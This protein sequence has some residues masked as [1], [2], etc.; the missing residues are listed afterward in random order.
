MTLQ[1]LEYITVLADYGQFVDAAEACG[2]SQSTLSLMVKKLESELDVV[3]FDR[4]SHPITPTEMGKRIIEKARVIL[5]NCRQLDEMT[6]AEKQQ[7]TGTLK[8]GMISTAAPVLQPGMFKYFRT[9]YPNIKLEEVEMLTSSIKDK[10]RKAELDMG[11][12]ASPVDDPDFL[13]IPLYSEEFLAYVSPSCKAYNLEKIE[14]AALFNFP[15]W[16]MKDTVH[17]A[18][19]S[20]LKENEDFSYEKFYEGGRAGTMIQIVNECGG[21]TVVPDSHVNLI[22]YSLHKHLR[23]IINPVPKRNICLIIRQ[24][25]IHEAVLNAVLDA[26]KSIVPLEKQDNIL[27]HGKL[28]L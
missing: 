7:L 8:V 20:K 15:L 23:P 2:V 3:I 27:K 6:K 25:Y 1:Q 14:S 19:R 18:D 9:E 26:V 4:N 28:S 10:I 13:E 17:L 16:I 5:Y 12:I 22:M 21:M 11:V 24:D